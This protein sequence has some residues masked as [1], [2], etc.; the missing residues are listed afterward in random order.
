[1]LTLLTTWLLRSRRDLL[2]DNLALRQKLA[3]STKRHSLSHIGA[4]T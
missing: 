1:M 2:L 4:R 3:V